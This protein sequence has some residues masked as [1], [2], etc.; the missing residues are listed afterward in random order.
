MSNPSPAP[1]VFLKMRAIAFLCITAASFLWIILLCFDM[2]FRW[3]ISDTLEQALLVIILFVNCITII[4]LPILILVPFRVWLDA[5]RFLLLLFTHIGCAVAFVYWN[6]RFVC[7]D[8]TPDQLSLCQTL[9]MYILLGN[10]VIPGLLITYSCGLAAMLCIRSQPEPAF[11]TEHKRFKSFDEESYDSD[12]QSITLPPPAMIERGTPLSITIPS[13]RYAVRS[14]IR[15]SPRGSMSPIVPSDRYILRGSQM[16][17][18]LART[19]S[20]GSLETSLFR[21]AESPP[22]RSTRLIKPSPDWSM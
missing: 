8:Q 7:P 13:D 10:W 19:E 16:S 2:Y 17:S 22:R 14:S 6:P 5:A 21:G 18:P 4:V 1:P 11:D 12:A 20:S 9:N 15:S 3:N